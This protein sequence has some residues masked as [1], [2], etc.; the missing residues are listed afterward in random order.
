M[1]SQYIENG[2]AMDN[3]SR[4]VRVETVIDHI[5]YLLERIDKR[6]DGLDTKMSER[7]EKMDNCNRELNN[8]LDSTM[9]WLVGIGITSLIS[10][11]GAIIT[12]RLQ[13]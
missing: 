8:R 7:F 10:V 6:F 3:E 12:L 13:G 2:L 9:R 1:Q 4:I 11:F 5:Q